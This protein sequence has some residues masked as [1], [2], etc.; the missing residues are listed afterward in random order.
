MGVKQKCNFFIKNS[1]SLCFWL[2]F[3]C[4]NHFWQIFCYPDPFRETNPDPGG[5]NDADSYDS[6]PKRYIKE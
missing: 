6:D 3:P 5:R 1:I 2:I 4:F